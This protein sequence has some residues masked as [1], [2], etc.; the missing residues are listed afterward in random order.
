MESVFLTVLNMSLTASYVIIAIL[1]TR[2]LLKNA[3]KRYSY[4]LWAAAAFRLICPISFEAVFSLFQPLDL[5]VSQNTMTSV[6][7]EIG[8]QRYPQ[9]HLGIPVVSEAVSQALPPANLV[10]S[11]NPI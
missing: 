8:F 6:S 2:F 3:P 4:V 7:P 5:Q 11:V 10:G 9:V 1:L